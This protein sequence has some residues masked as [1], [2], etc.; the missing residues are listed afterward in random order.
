MVA[1][2]SVNSPS[3]IYV[4]NKANMKNTNTQNY[5]SAMRKLLVVRLVAGKSAMNDICPPNRCG[6]QTM[7]ALRDIN[8]N[9][10]DVEVH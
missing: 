2:L 8:E 4:N 10:D 7:K 3:N 6:S 9:D 5:T 1:N